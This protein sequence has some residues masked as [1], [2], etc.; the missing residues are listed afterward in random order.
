MCNC[1]NKRGAL[2]SQQSFHLSNKANTAKEG[3]K[4]WPE[5]NF[6]YTGKTALS[7]RGSVSGKSYRFSK[8]GD[9]QLVD[10]RDAASLMS[11]SVLKTIR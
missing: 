9:I 2:A 10:Y 5:V 4:I 6:K 8:P 3:D 7:V 11:V 1:G